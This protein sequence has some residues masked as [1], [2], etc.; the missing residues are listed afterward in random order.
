ML[1]KP[2]Q[3]FDSFVTEIKLQAD[4][5]ELGAAYDRNIKDRIIQG[6]RDDVLRLAGEIASVGGHRLRLP[7]LVLWARFLQRASVPQGL[8]KTL[9]LCKSAELSKLH[10]LAM[11]Q[12]QPTSSTQV[13]AISRQGIKKFQGQINSSKQQY[14]NSKHSRN[15]KN[16][17]QHKQRPCSRCGSHHTPRNRPAYG[18]S[19]HNC[20]MLNHFTSVCR[21]PKRQPPPKY[22]HRVS[23]IECNPDIAYIGT[24]STSQQCDWLQEIIINDFP[25]T[26]KL[27]TG[28]QVN[29]L[30]L[31]VIRKLKNQPSIH[32]TSL[33]VCTYTGD[34]LPV[35]G[36]SVFMYVVNNQHR[37]LKFIV[38]DLN[39]Q[40]V[41]SAAACTALNLIQ[42]IDSSLQVNEKCNVNLVNTQSSDNVYSSIVTSHLSIS[43][44][45]SSNNSIPHPHKLLKLIEEYSDIFEG[46]GLI[47]G[48]HK[49]I[50]HED[51][52]PVIAA[53]RKILLALE[54]KLKDEL[55]RMEQNCIIKKVTKPTDSV[56][57]IVVVP[58]KDGSIRVC[59]DPRPLNKYIKRQHYHIPLQAQLL[60]KLNG[61]KVF[62]LLDAKNAFYHIQLDEESSDIC[63]FITPFGRESGLKLNKDKAKIAVSEL[64]YL[65]HIISPDGVS[66]DPKEVSAV[67]DLTV[68]TSKQ[69]LMRFLG[70]YLAVA[71]A[72]S[73][74]PL[75]THLVSTSDIDNAQLMVSLLVQASKSK[76]DEILLETKNHIEPQSMANYIENGWP[77][78]KSVV[79]NAQPYWHCQSELYIKNGLI[80]RGQRLV[81]PNSYRKD[82]LQCLHIGHRGI[83][84]CRNL[85]R[86]S[87]YWP[88]MSTE[89]ENRVSHCDIC[90]QNQKSNSKDPLLDRKL[91]ER[92]WQK[93]A[94]DFFHL[95]S[96]TYLLIVDYFSKYIELQHLHHC[97]VVPQ[98]LN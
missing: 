96:V 34:A 57:P 28:A 29:V 50:L 60:S 1:Q 98:H 61:S 42:R 27:D 67:T 19:C 8:K 20:Q 68:P 74:A 47:P 90:Q 14:N 10:S 49:I 93:V 24:I 40:P 63:T 13:D 97:C 23:T 45:N 86:Q 54:N 5:C 59:L 62:S 7:A 80:C 9:E 6:L 87:L 22:Q 91:S 78:S 35:V 53:S 38:V 43:V 16:P 76:L 84:S 32:P 15:N 79:L 83:V 51:A 65:G 66:P 73:R 25:V 92:P 94:T 52:T 58:K 18:K 17:A 55:F 37:E 12:P 39:G 4:Q 11:S 81:I 30:P 33:E 88:G 77:E 2:G 82:V 75:P 46:V 85:A 3:N 70:K 56:N 44:P 72:L 95:S 41:L 36:E 69:D 26:F 21:Q 31:S 71:D 64:Q 89:I 48:K